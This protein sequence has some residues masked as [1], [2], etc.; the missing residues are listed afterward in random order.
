MFAVLGMDCACSSPATGG[1]STSKSGS[2]ESERERGPCSDQISFSGRGVG[3][4]YSF[5]TRHCITTLGSWQASECTRRR[6]SSSY[7]CSSSLIRRER[8]A[9]A[10][11]R[12]VPPFRAWPRMRQ[13]LHLWRWQGRRLRIRHAPRG[14]RLKR[15][16]NGLHLY[17]RSFIGLNTYPN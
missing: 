8:L 2:T 6:R 4:T 13:G 9:R 5:Y 11:M 7:P 16:H 1:I 12:G 10:S 17:C 14:K 15:R 3:I